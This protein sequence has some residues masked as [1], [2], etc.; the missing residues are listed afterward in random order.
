MSVT[1]TIQYPID[2]IAWDSGHTIV[3]TLINGTHP[4]ERFGKHV[5]Q[6]VYARCK[7]RIYYAS[8]PRLDVVSIMH[9]RGRI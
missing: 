1:S 4:Y 9:K 8:N 5:I 7:Y 2:V 3:S 6:D